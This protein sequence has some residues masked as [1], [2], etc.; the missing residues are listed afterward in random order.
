M[1]CAVKKVDVL[2]PSPPHPLCICNWGGGGG[3]GVARVYVCLVFVYIYEFTRQKGKILAT[4]LTLICVSVRQ[5]KVA[6]P[7]SHLARTF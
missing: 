2:S 5:P 6:C 4:P 7:E 1:I 3:G